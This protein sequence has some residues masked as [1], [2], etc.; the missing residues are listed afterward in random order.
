MRC[1]FWNI[2][3]RHQKYFAM[4][5]KAGRLRQG[6]GYEPRLDLR[7]LKQKVDNEKALDDAE[8]KCWKGCS[9]MLHSIE[10]GD[11][12]VVKHVPAHEMF[13]I[14]KINGPYDF[15]MDS[16][17][18]DFGHLLPVTGL[19]EYNKLSGNVPAPF[20][21]ALDRARSR[22]ISTYNHADSVVTLYER[23]HADSDNEPEE[24][25]SRIRSWRKALIPPLK[26]VVRKG[27]RHK[28]AERLI[29]LLLEQRGISVNFTAGRNE[30]GA[31][32]LGTA[33]FAS[34]GSLDYS[35]AVQVKMHRGVENDTTGLDQ[36]ERALAEHE[37]DA[38][39]LVSF[40]DELG[41]AVE[42]SLKR[43]KRTHNIEVLYGDDLYSQ[44]LNLIVDGD[45]AERD[46]AV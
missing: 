9:P 8:Q 12:V 34:L 41:E 27:L 26:E 18:G 11:L 22:I 29:K 32:T 30:R 1:W 38:C 3:V 44:L 6:W 10:E 43:L 16:K 46:E 31:D 14:V 15:R 42:K 25:R 36:L 23:K 35:V 5:L 40:A 24:L 19:R 39:L 20:A 28:S 2:D 33:S 37:V 13:T 7:K 21:S 17:V 4:E 45:H